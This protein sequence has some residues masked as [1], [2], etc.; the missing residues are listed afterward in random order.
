MKTIKGK[1]AQK[2]FACLVLL[3][4]ACMMF[5]GCGKFEY[6]EDG[7]KKE[8][9]H[10]NLPIQ[11]KA[12]ASSE[13]F[14][15]DDVTFDLYYGLYNIDEYKK[16]GY[17]PQNTYQRFVDDKIF[18]GLYVCDSEYFYDVHNDLEFPDYTIIDNYY[19]IRKISEEEAFS[20][21]Y[22]YTKNYWKGI[23]YNHCETITIPSEIF[24]K[25][26]GVFVIKIVGFIEPYG[27]IDNYYT[28]TT[29]YIDFKY[30]VID[31]TT[32][33]VMFEPYSYV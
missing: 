27:E 12:T 5:T 18:F 4:A 20:G 29:G 19:F 11:F 7:V 30:Q 17:K 3:L 6:V 21:E 22:G 2:L 16:T 1:L 32:V 24:S 8:Y 10:R 26:S 9:K 23:T 14:E 33:Q 28:S 15:I 25:E 13:F 31:E